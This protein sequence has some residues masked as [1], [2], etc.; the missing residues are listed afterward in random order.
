VLGDENWS[1]SEEKVIGVGNQV[2]L[3]LSTV[4][5][6]SAAVCFRRDLYRV[7]LAKREG[8]RLLGRPRRRTEENVEMD[9][10]EVGV[11]VWNE[12]NCLEI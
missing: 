9:H 1:A 3:Y 4:V 11:G 6:S 12:L 7:V 8:R 5:I 10:Q 2:S